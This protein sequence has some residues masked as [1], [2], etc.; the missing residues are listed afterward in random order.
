M[1]IK[2][3]NI[4][5]LINKEQKI[6]KI[7]LIGRGNISNYTSYYSRY[8][9]NNILNSNFFQILGHGLP[10]IIKVTNDNVGYINKLLDF[11]S[12]ISQ[13]DYLSNSLRYDQVYFDADKGF[14]IDDMIYFFNCNLP[15]TNPIITQNINKFV[16]EFIK[17]LYYIYQNKLT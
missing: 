16:N 7:Y 15:S 11:R 10:I 13:I 9:Y 8:I 5:N 14:Q 4:D 1:K 17:I 6:N 3:Q 2:I 12:G